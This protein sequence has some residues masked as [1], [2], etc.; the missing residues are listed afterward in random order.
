MPF[1]DK[2]LEQPNATLLDI[3]GNDLDP[4]DMP[5]EKRTHR[6]DHGRA[7][8]SDGTEL[9]F[10]E[11]VKFAP[12]NHAENGRVIQVRLRATPE[13]GPSILIPRNVTKEYIA[14]VIERLIKGV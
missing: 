11:T 4:P 6:F 10:P 3:D 12:D 1:H 13:N 5:E 8:F 7:I 2:K 9:K 14:T